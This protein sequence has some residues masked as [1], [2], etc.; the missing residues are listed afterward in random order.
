MAEDHQLAAVEGRLEFPQHLRP[1]ILRQR[2]HIR[3]IAGEDHAAM[4]GDRELP[5]VVRAGPEIRRHAAL[6]AD[7]ATERHALQV[8]LQVVVP[9]VVNAGE[10]ARVAVR[11]AADGRAA[12]CALVDHRVDPALLVARD[13]DGRVA[14]EGRL[15]VAGARDLGFER[16]V[17]PGRP[18][19]NALHLACVDCLVGVDPVRNLRQVARPH[20][21]AL[22]QHR[23]APAGV[24]CFGATRIC[25]DCLCAHS[26]C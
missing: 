21:L 17:V 20:V 19:K 14:D 9:L 5:R 4:G 1:E 7:A 26:H 6:P 25:C 2:L 22:E 23:V 8:A 16:D 13:D 15:V 3:R 18:V 12:V 11:L 10:V 24:K